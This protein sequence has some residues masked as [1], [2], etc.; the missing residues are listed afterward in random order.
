MTA[1]RA[2]STHK[3]NEPFF[4]G[5]FALEGDD[6][7]R[8]YIIRLLHPE[9]AALLERFDKAVKHG[10]GPEWVS[11]YPEVERYRIRT[12]RLHGIPDTERAF[13]IKK[14]AASYMQFMKDGNLVFGLFDTEGGISNG[15]LLAKA[16]I[17]VNAEDITKLGFNASSRVYQAAGA[18]FGKDS[19][20]AVA[21]LLGTFPGL[22]G[23]GLQRLVLDKAFNHVANP[24]GSGFAPKTAIHA[25]IDPRNTGSIKS[26]LRRG[27]KIYETQRHSG[28]GLDYFSLVGSP[29]GEQRWKFSPDDLKNLNGTIAD[30]QRRIG[31]REDVAIPLH[32]DIEFNQDLLK[33]ENLQLI[34]NANKNG[35]K[36]V[37]VVTTDQPY[38]EGWYDDTLS[39]KNQFTKKYDYLVMK[40]LPGEM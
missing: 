13:F 34:W 32:V 24:N 37:D 38:T 16:A 23:L 33:S 15:S 6:Q 28:N 27:F 39:A 30:V 7:T 4:P 20:R 25:L 26:F 22:Q 3:H 11:K 10:I 40:P 36:G 9:D 12:D 18:S 29:V 31:N 17:A 8:D 2:I 21:T 14:D 35:Y 5:H 1:L 19:P